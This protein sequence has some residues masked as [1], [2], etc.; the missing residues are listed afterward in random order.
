MTIER[1][2]PTETLTNVQALRG[3]AAMLVVFVHLQDLAML[4]GAR[5]DVFV[6]GN[7]GVDIFFVISGLIMVQSTARR[8]MGPVEFMRR[9]VTRVAPLYWLVTL[10]VFALL[11]IKPD[12]FGST[13]ADPDH[14]AKSLAFVPYARGDG[15][16][17]PIV[18]LGWTLN[19]EMA[20]YLLFAA[21]LA[22][23]N[24]R[25][26]WAPP[27]LAIVAVVAAGRL[28]KPADPVLGFYAAP[29][30]L[31]FA[32]GMVLGAL[33][34]KRPLP[35]PVAKALI[36]LGVVAF[37]LMML[38]PVLLPNSER[39]W[40]AGIPAAIV[41]AVA[42]AAERSGFALPWRW[43]Q[44]LGDASY[45]IYLTHFFVTAAMTKLAAR[46]GVDS[47]WMGGALMLAALVLVVAVGWA[48][49]RWIE[50]PITNLVQNKTRRRAEIAP[51]AI[52]AA[53]PAEM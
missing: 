43:P 19:Y 38:A 25:W 26:R 9:R 15:A 17:H 21:G 48:T 39:A 4:S 33:L 37:G 27:L 30:V 14:L 23:S 51:P 13:T 24:G 34:P 53:Q 12:L 50:T 29:I 31:E 52:A 41:V 10:A 2:A 7:T 40:I 49:Y 22:I 20:F 11:L 36:G 16:M 5:G 35:R 46:L 1:G 8:P 32:A 28:L 42:V 6:W 44:R 18:F 3:L 45:S 47:A